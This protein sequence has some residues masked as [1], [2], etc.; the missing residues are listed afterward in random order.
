MVVS[1]ERTVIM[2]GILSSL[3]PVPTDK[4]GIVLSSGTR[5]LLK[6]RMVEPLRY[7]IG[8]T[9]IDIR[10]NSEELKL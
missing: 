4:T 1:F 7:P 6:R 10:R 3:V 8:Q 9:S 5:V 2:M